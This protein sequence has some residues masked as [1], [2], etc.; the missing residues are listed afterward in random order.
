M[1]ISAIAAMDRN[2][3]I[4]REGKLPWKLPSDLKRFRALTMGKPVIMGRKTFDSLGRTPLYGRKNIV[5]TRSSPRIVRDDHRSL[6]WTN[7]VKEALLLAEDEGADEAFIVGGRQIYGS[8]SRNWEKFYLTLVLGDFKPEGFQY[9]GNPDSAYT[10][11]PVYGLERVPWIVQE[12]RFHTKAEG[13]DDSYWT[14]EL[15][16]S[17][18]VVMPGDPVFDFKIYS[19]FLL[20]NGKGDA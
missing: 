16:R 2:G 6:I 10:C 13:D 7:S 15:K 3:I 8:T 20:G 9:P 1:R 4:G 11:F 14:L 12:I 17:E 19:D 5:V 18:A